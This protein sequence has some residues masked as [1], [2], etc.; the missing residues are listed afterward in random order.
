MTNKRFLLKANFC[1]L[2]LENWSPHNGRY[3]RPVS[4]KSLV[5]SFTCRMTQTAQPA[6]RAS[7]NVRRVRIFNARRPV[8]EV[9]VGQVRFE[10]SWQGYAYN[11]DS[12]HA[13]ALRVQSPESSVLWK[14]RTSGRQRGKDLVYCG[15]VLP[16][17]TVVVGGCCWC[18]CCSCWC[19]CCCC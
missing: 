13:Y 9:A 7:G 11:A 15:K 3:A 19:C 8:P 4:A 10:H 2:R 14:Q 16:E 1:G 6:R 5:P 12:R 18:C 17:V